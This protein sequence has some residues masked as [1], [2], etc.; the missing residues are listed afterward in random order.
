M[1]TEWMMDGEMLCRSERM[2]E[3]GYK[4]Y[5]RTFLVIQ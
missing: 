3:T 2:V 1:L 5:T 4:T